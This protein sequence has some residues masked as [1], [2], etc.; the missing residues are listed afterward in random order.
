LGRKRRLTK[1]FTG[2]RLDFMLKECCWASWAA[3]INKKERWKIKKEID[4]PWKWFGAM[5][6]G[7]PGGWKGDGGGGV[8]VPTCLVSTQGLRQISSSTDDKN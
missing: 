7:W 1:I 4:I 3:G 6:E 5:I 8:Q 2:G